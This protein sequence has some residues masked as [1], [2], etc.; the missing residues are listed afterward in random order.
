MSLTNMPTIVFDT[1]TGTDSTTG[2]SGASGAGPATAVAGSAAFA[3]QTT[4]EAVVGFFEVSDPDLSGVAT[5]GSHVLWF[6]T[7]SGRQ[8][9][10]IS[11]VNNSATF[12]TTGT[13]ATNSSSLTVASGSGI[14]N[15]DILK[16]AGAGT[17]GTDLYVQVTAGGGT[18]TLTL[19][20]TA[21]TGVSGAAVTRP[22]NVGTEDTFSTAAG[23]AWAIGG[24]RNS[25]DQTNSRLLFTAD[26]KAGWTIQTDTAQTISSSISLTGVGDTT[27][28][29]VS[30]VG[31][32]GALRTITQSANTSHLG[33]GFGTGIYKFTNLTFVNSNGTKTSANAIGTSGS[34]TFTS[35][36][37]GDSGGTNNIQRAINLAANT[38]IYNLVD[39]EIVNTTSDGIF[40]SI[41]G[42]I[43]LLG[44]KVHG[45]GGAG[46]N[47]QAIIAVQ[48]SDCTIYG[49]TSN[50]IKKT[51][52][53]LTNTLTVTDSTIHGNGA[54]GIDISG[55][56]S[57]SQGI[58]IASNNITG[59]T[60]YG[61][62]AL[63][64]ADA[65]RV[66]IDYNNFGTGSTANTSGNMQNL[67]AGAHDLTVDPGYTSAA[68]GNFTITSTSNVVAKGFPDSSRTIGA[69]TGG[70][71]S[72]VDIGASQAQEAAGGTTFVAGGGAPKQTRKVVYISRNRPMPFVTTNPLL[73][74]ARRTIH[75]R[76]Y[77]R[78]YNR[79]LPFL[80]TNYTPIPSPP[81]R[82]Q[83]RQYY[84]QKRPIVILPGINT[85]ATVYV[86]LPG[87][88]KLQPARQ[89]P[90][91]TR[92]LVI[93]SGNPIL[94]PAPPRMR[95]IRQPWT[96]LQRIAI[97]TGTGTTTTIVVPVLYPPRQRTPRN[98]PARTRS[99]V[100]IQQNPILIPT[101][102]RSNQ[103]SYYPRR[104]GRAAAVLPVQT[105]QVPITIRSPRVH[106]R[107][108]YPRR[109]PTLIIPGVTTV[110]TVMVPIAKP[111]RVIAGKREPGRFRS[112]VITTS[113][114][115]L[116]PVRQRGAILKSYYPRR[117]NIAAVLVPDQIP[118]V[119]RRPIAQV[120]VPYPVRRVVA[121]LPLPGP[122]VHQPVPFPVPART[123]I[124][125]ALFPLKRVT[126]AL[127]L[128][129]PTVTV[130]VPLSGHRRLWIGQVYY[131]KLRPAVGALLPQRT[132]TVQEPVPVTSR[133][134]QYVRLY[135]PRARPVVGCL[136][137]GPVRLV[138]L[139]SP[140]RLV[141]YRAPMQR[142][143]QRACAALFQSVNVTNT[144]LVQNRLLVR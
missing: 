15:G 37:F 129:A 132:V 73:I 120:R 76:G 16:I 48:I 45:C 67:T 96:R 87:R 29:A 84:P 114:T 74:T 13:V 137:P 66:F 20:H 90:R 5:D 116:L 44:C 24:K 79:L 111:P 133:R 121:A 36:V 32:S 123:R 97:S 92:N 81:R 26:V 52:G 104:V 126:A 112:A 128:P 124:V 51:T 42:T 102:R 135:Y 108:H 86:P 119:M 130:R 91:P 62:K 89:L 9:T 85:T 41:G 17:G 139:P 57:A 78:Q 1:G 23:V 95:Q 60:G 50:G 136:L 14:A 72:Y 117:V 93:I 34:V 75:T 54:D 71:A 142:T 127:P 107:S 98:T 115:V 99:V 144:V 43:N 88:A 82:I 64:V 49:C 38:S 18:T 94:L 61:I 39:C 70:T 59:N 55:A 40:M 33:G 6:L 31:S 58:V 25:F 80:A 125:R 35:C 46:V 68:T 56:A 131:P 4:A 7:S 140:R 3:C 103:R 69:N 47:V 118:I 10:R 138:P 2:G 83:N 122:V 63:A 101:H 22:K 100:L 143:A 105:I 109:L 113:N 21:P 8:W 110:T 141:Q 27:N 134:V 53:S 65:L 77:T 11:T 19:S 30:I 28:G 12:T 106:T